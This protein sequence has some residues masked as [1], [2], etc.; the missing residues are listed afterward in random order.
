M[1]RWLSS[2][3][4]AALLS[5]TGAAHAL[6]VGGLVAAD[7]RAFVLGPK[8]VGQSQGTGVSLVAEPEFSL[9][10]EDEAHLAKLHPFYRLD[11]IDERRSHPDLREGFYRLKLQHWEM[12]LGVGQFTWGVLESHRPSDV[13]SSGALRR[14]VG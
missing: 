3:F 5:S 6:D 8:Y 7:G 13:T 4:A 2:A 10:T 1:K 12:G 11:P 9:K 14:I